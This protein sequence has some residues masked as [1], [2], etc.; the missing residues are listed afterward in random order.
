MSHP[1]RW[2][3]GLVTVTLAITGSAEV[4]LAA[5]ASAADGSCAS[6]SVDGSPAV[7]VPLTASVEGG[8]AGARFTWSGAGFGKPVQGSRFTASDHLVGSPVHLSV[9]SGAGASGVRA[10]CDLDPVGWGH[11][12]RPAAPE[13]TGRPEL[14]GTL[15]ARPGTG[16]VVPPRGTYHFEWF[17]G[18]SPS[19]FATGDDVTLGAAQVGT[20]ITVKVMLTAHGYRDSAWSEPSASDAVEGVLTRPDVPTIDGSPE[21]GLVLRAVPG[22]GDDLP[23]AA[24][25]EYQWL[26]DGEQFAAG[27]EVTLAAP[28]LGRAVT[29][30]VR[31]TAPGWTSSDWSTS[32]PTAPVVRGHLAAPSAVTISGTPRAGES[33]T[34]VVTGS[35]TPGT[36]V[37]FTWKADGVPFG[38]GLGGVVLTGAEQGKSITVAITGYLAG[39]ADRTIESAAVGPV[40]PGS[41]LAAPGQPSIAGTARVGSLLTAVP[42]AVDPTWPVGTTYSYEWSADGTP[43]ATGGEVT[44]GADQ[45]GRVITLRTR[46][47]APGQVD[48]AWSEASAPTTAVTGGDLA[49]PSSV[50]VTGRPRVGETLTAATSGAWTPGTRVVYAWR[51]DGVAFGGDTRQVE[52]GADQLGARITVTVTGTLSGYEPE[53]VTSDRSAR[54]DRGRLDSAKPKIRGTA[55]VGRTLTVEPGTWTRGADLAYQWFAGGHRIGG[56]TGSRLVLTGRLAHQRISVEVTG[57]LDGYRS[58]T[59]TSRA[60]GKVK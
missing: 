38:S 45:M 47:S 48:S 33:L 41:V 22:A 58:V 60:T 7:G 30:R 53:S 25:Y 59:R 3:T 52:L 49:A 35:W 40:A 51:A 15:H 55:R 12:A 27:P 57:T 9:R 46:V 28:Q 37:G 1:T 31:A 4:A 56:A 2:A 6:V 50:S 8:S 29:V 34:A 17:S 10:E 19:A 18:D 32:A 21:V 42:T 36:S 24:T 23:D 5:P 13:V 44:L 26:A 43:F 20:R 54:V 39:Y 14:G 11:I 16:D